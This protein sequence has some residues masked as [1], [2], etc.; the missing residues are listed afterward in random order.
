MKKFTGMLAVVFLSGC[1]WYE[2]TTN[3]DSQM[4]SFYDGSPTLSSSEYITDNSYPKGQVLTAYKGFTVVDR[5]TFRKEV[6]RSEE[7][8]ATSDGEMAGASVPLKFKVNE[9]RKAI[10]QV[11]LRDGAYMLLEA[12]MPNY[13][14]LVNQEGEVYNKIGVI[15]NS[16]LTLLETS[17]RIT[18]R[19]FHFEVVSKSSSV[20]TRPV[21]GF[22]I[23]YE[24]INL[25]RL[26]F[27]YYDYSK[28]DGATG[29]FENITFPQSQ[30][31]IEI[32]GSGF[33]VLKATPSKLD[34]IIIK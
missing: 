7:V 25:D 9:I 15:K 8:R 33:K 11:Q 16:R 18:P 27:T 2:A 5:K 6:Y 1:S 4:I 32:D 34:Y 14:I 13:V 28:S 3:I 17:Y 24:G 21:K 22:D 19:N 10:G 29:Y 30:Q 20:Q 23:K 31:I 12:D 26:V